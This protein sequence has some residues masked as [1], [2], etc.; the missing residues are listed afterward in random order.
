MK[1]QSMPSGHN[2]MQHISAIENLAEQLKNM[3]EPQTVLQITTKIMYSLPEHLRGFINSWENLP[4][5][6]QTVSLLISKVLNEESK[7]AMFQPQ[8]KHTHTQKKKRG[9]F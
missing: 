4:D 3:G 5:E 6:K 9:N 8:G 2:A 1:F 7:Y